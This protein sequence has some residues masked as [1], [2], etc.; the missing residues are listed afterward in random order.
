MTKLAFTLL[1]SLFLTSAVAPDVAQWRGPNRDGIYNETGLLKKWPDGGPKLVW[2]F[3][4]LGDGHSSAAVTGKGV[5]TTGMIDGTGYL[6]AFSTEGKLLWKKEYGREWDKNWNGTRS[7]PLV[8]DDK[9]YLL[10]THWL[11]SCFNA[12]N[13]QTIW[14]ADLKK[15][16]EPRVNEW[17]MAENLLFD[18]DVVYCTPGRPNAS[19]LAY[20]RN[21]GKLIWKSKGNGENSAFCSP[22]MIKLA[23]RKIIVTMLAKSICGFDSGTGQMLWQFEHINATNVHPNIPVVIKFRCHKNK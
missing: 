13:G 7:T 21:S 22:L 17:R 16:F 2:H 9:I 3:D 19:L 10:S 20:N 14:T 8:I 1:A 5:F 6:F 18:G 4:Q 15:D 11:L 12:S 23:N